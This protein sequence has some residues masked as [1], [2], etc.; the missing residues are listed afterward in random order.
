MSYEGKDLKEPLPEAPWE[1]LN[2]WVRRALSEDN[3]FEPNAMSLATSTNDGKPSNRIVL[4]KEVR[5]EGIVFYTNYESRKGREIENN[6]HVAATI[7]WPEIF[8][9]VR[10]EGVAEKVSEEE[11]TEYFHSRPKG[12]QLGALI[13]DQSEVIESKEELME[14]LNKA[15]E[16]YEDADKV[17][18]PENWGGYYIETH[19]I[20]FWQGQPN[21]LHDRIRYRKEKGEWTRE[22]LAP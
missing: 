2:S 13:S 10:L 3:I 7:W 8:R 1:L 5:E 6:P 11:S 14:Q 12:S 16:K 4:F 18:R 22:R 15:R 9:Q 17:D 20:E 19:T 21:R